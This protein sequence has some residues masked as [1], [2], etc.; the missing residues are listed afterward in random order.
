MKTTQKE[1]KN[2]T[3]QK[4]IAR[5]QGDVYVYNECERMQHDVYKEFVSVVEE[6]INSESLVGLKVGKFGKL[7]Q[8]CPSLFTKN[9]TILIG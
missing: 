4:I 8:F 2:I 5:Q 3:K 7:C 9:L 6:S 1:K